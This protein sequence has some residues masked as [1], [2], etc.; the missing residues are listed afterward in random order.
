MSGKTSGT[1]AITRRGFLVG[2]ASM[3]S[4]AL[5]AA[6]GGSSAAPTG[7]AAATSALPATG[8]TPAASTTTGSTT[9]GA[10]TAAASGSATKLSGSVS[11]WVY[12]LLGEDQAKNESLWSGIIKDFTAQNPGVKVDVQVLPWA[13][14]D[15]KLT[16]A[17]AGNKGPDVCYINEDQIAQHVEAGTMTPLDEY[18]SAEER[19]DYLPNALTS[20]TYKGKLY[21]APILLTSTTIAYNT[22][23]FK[24]AGVDTYPTT[25]DELLQVAPKFKAKGLFATSYTGAL[26]QSLNLSYYPLLWQADGKVLNEDGTAG[27]NS[28]QGIEALTYVT[29][30]FSE[31][32][33]DKSESVTRPAEGQSGLDLSK[34]ATGLVVDNSGAQRLAKEWG[35]GVIKIGTPLKNKKQISYGTVAGFGLFSAQKSKDASVAWIKYLTSPTVAKQIILPGQLLPHEKV[36]RCALR[37]RSA[38]RRVRE[39]SAHDARRGAPSESASGHQHPRT[40]D[41]S[42]LP[43]QEDAAASAR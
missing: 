31:G 33:V 35:A 6:C 21:T 39:D 13:N 38:P 3:A 40:G 26:D 20:A 16:T 25:W 22:K 12:P 43:R 18:L 8:A 24:D 10:P 36:H 27:F 14:R 34:A 23:L 17:L 7:T 28:P 5:L 32:F 30:L 42:R 4:A 37:E 41:S 2:A 19:A 15:D 29:K 11:M 1:A 9:G